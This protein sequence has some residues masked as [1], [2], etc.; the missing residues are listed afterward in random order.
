MEGVLARQERDIE[1]LGEGE[2]EGEVQIKV[3]PD[4]ASC[5]EVGLFDPMVL[6]VLCSILSA[7]NESRNFISAWTAAWGVAVRDRDLLDLTVN[8]NPNPLW[9]EKVT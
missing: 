3:V 5:L 4:D 7:S 6:D 1:R 2:G 9:L 8:H